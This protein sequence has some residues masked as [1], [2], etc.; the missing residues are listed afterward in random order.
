M[1]NTCGGCDAAWTGLNTSHCAAEC[2]HRTFA[3]PSLFDKHRQAT[4]RVRVWV[5]Y[6]DGE[7]PFPEPKVIGRFVDPRKLQ[8]GTPEYRS[9]VRVYKTRTDVNDHVGAEVYGIEWRDVQIP[10]G[11]CVDPA[12]MTRPLSDREIELG[13]VGQC[14]KD[15]EFECTCHVAE[16]PVF[17][18]YGTS[19]EVTGGPGKRPDEVSVRTRAEMWRAYRLRDAQGEIIELGAWS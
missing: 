8:K 17:E 9:A 15:G 7:G 16:V 6:Q 2:C 10:H 11:K 5:R 12:T 1:V 19:Y 3:G 13:A 4:E 14:V 18:F